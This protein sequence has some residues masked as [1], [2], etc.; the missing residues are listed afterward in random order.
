M[1]NKEGSQTSQAEGNSEDSLL[2][3]Q[4]QKHFKVV[5]SLLQGNK[6]FK[7]EKEEGVEVLC[8]EW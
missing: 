2:K 6:S 5:Q 4:H 1:Y 8:L 7:G 3:Q